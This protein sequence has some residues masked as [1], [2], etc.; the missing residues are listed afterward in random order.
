MKILILDRDGVINYD[1]DDFIKNPD[2]WE[3]L[4][5]SI[6][7]I[8]S[9]TKANYKIIICTNQS[10]IGRK[11]FTMETLNDIHHKMQRMI[12]QQ[13]G[14]IAAIFIC[15]HTPEDNCTCR[16]PKSQMVLNICDRFNVEDISNVMLVGDSLRDLVAIANVGGVPVL[17][18]TGKGKETLRGNDLPANTLVFNNL[19]E[20]SDY[21]LEKENN[22]K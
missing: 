21:L 16:K 10:G 6:E 20:V 12:E 17:V 19:L 3:P 15:P 18:K 8:S 2:E 9:L 22:E 13:G 7:A 4:P 11:L 5:G 14:K 1:S